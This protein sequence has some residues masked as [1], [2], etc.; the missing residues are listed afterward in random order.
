LGAIPLVPGLAPPWFG[1]RGER[2]WYAWSAVF[3]A[4]VLTCTV[5]G[6]RRANRLLRRRLDEKAS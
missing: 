3:V 5:V 6:R 2:R 1:W 4:G